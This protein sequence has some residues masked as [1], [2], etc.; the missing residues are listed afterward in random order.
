MSNP[1]SPLLPEILAYYGQGREDDR[2]LRGIG[3]LEL[4]R[5]QELLTRYLPPPPGVVYDIGGGS[6]RYA[7]WLARRGYEVHLIDAAPLHVEQ[8]LA[9]SAAQPDSPL[10]SVTLGDARS[11]Q[12]PTAPPVTAEDA[13]GAAAVTAG[14]AAVLV[15]GPLYHLTDRDDRVIALREARRITRSGGVL[16]AAGI[17]QFASALAGLVDGTL[18][19][20][21]FQAVVRQDLA[22]GQHRN[23]DADY[24]APEHRDYFTTAYFHHPFA[25][26]AEVEEA[27]WAACRLLAVEG[28]AWIPGT[29]DAWWDDDARREI[30]LDT[31]R[32][33]EAEPTLLGA[34]A[35]ILAV[36]HAM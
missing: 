26:R 16:L 34:S 6:G 9:A 20:P 35:H 15:L 33:V 31:V 19:D 7:C 24:G 17:S 11:L 14:A 1:D 23:P 2:L 3:R 25:L 12:V 36:A 28:P 22:D 10:A 4:A 18:T 27:G 30:L 29:F 13:A 32:A 8:A 21:D 5:T